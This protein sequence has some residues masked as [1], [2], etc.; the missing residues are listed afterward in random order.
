MLCASENETKGR[1]EDP[2]VYILN[3][4]YT[5]NVWYASAGVLKLGNAWVF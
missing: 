3:L 4:I 1:F 2:V 5:G